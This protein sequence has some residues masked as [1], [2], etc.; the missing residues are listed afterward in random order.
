MLSFF[1]EHSFQVNIWQSYKQT[2]RWLSH[3]LSSSFSTAVSRRTKSTFLTC[4]FAKYLPTHN[5][6]FTA[7]LLNNLPVKRLGRFDS[8]MAMSVC[9]FFWLSQYV[10]HGHTDQWVW[11]PAWGFLYWFSRVASVFRFPWTVIKWKM[12][13]S[14]SEV[15]FRRHAAVGLN[16]YMTFRFSKNSKLHYM[17]K[18]SSGTCCIY[19]WQ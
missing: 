12:M 5:N 7:N 19:W 18:F 1:S 13:Y 10:P 15:P 8:I 6:H 11:L 16:E 14:Y 17:P 4:N 9:S 3:A 2:R